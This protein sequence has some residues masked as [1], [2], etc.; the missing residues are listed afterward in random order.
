[1]TTSELIS[2]SLTP[3]TRWI[4]TG[5]LLLSVIAFSITVMIANVVLPQ[6]MVS[7][8][9]DLDQAQWVLT[10]NGIAQTVMMPLVGW[11]TGLVG[12]RY[13]FLGGM[14]VFCIGATFSGMAWSLESLVFF[15]G[16]VGAGGGLMQPILMAIMYQMFPPKQRGLALGL[17]MV[18][19]SLGPAVAPIAGGYLVDWFSWRAAFYLSVPLGIVGL[20]CA[21]VTLPSLPRPSRQ[22]LDQFGLFSMTVGLVAL[23]IAF[24]Q[25]RREGWDSSYILTLFAVALVALL[26]FI[27]WE[28]CTSS[29]LVDLR[30]FRYLPFTLG[31]LVV[32]LATAAFR[33]TGVMSIVYMQRVLGLTPLDIGWLQLA[34]NLAFG[35]AVVLAGRLADK[36]GTHILVIVGLTFFALGSF[37]FSSVNEMVTAGTIILFLTYRLGFYGFITSPVNLSAMRAIPET[38]IVMASG[39]LSLVRGISGTMGPV[40][41]VTYYEQRYY[42]HI[43]RYAAENGLN[44]WGLQEA[45]GTVRQFLQGEG[46]PLMLLGVKTA[47]LLQ[48]RLLAEAT[49][50][51]Y[52]DYFFVAGLVSVGALWFALP[53]GAL[54]NFVRRTLRSV[55]PNPAL[56]A[57]STPSSTTNDQAT[58]TSV[59][60]HEA[61]RTRKMA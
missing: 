36:F 30:I 58:A 18:G 28:L 44:A 12:H 48:R 38:Q 53:W 29:P 50:I 16:L 6:I 8:R 20:I 19:W 25:G 3:R 4:A 11:L 1:M 45:L 21:W 61:A 39:L 23:L 55:R 42:V 52:Q 43:Q 32:F 33:G 60:A 5:S 9:A 37:T 41:S 59:P 15:Q 7:L 24:S 40:L 51:A 56:V 35:V 46:E 27:V 22:T 13:L 31:C 10:A 26:A 47:A 17:S 34:G 14:S 49:T 54:G 2:A 57:V